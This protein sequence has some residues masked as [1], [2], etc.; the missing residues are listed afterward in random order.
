METVFCPQ[1]HQEYELD[2]SVIGCRV[3][4]AI[5]ETEFIA[6]PSDCPADKGKKEDA[7]SKD[8][9]ASVSCP[10][11]K[12]ANKPETIFCVFCEHKIVN[13]NCPS[14]HATLVQ[15]AAFCPSCG[16]KVIDSDNNR[17]VGSED[18]SAHKL[19][20][21]FFL[22]KNNICDL[23][24]MLKTKFMNMSKKKRIAIVS[25]SLLVLLFCVF[26]ISSISGGTNSDDSAAN[27]RVTSRGY[28]E[29]QSEA[30]AAALLFLMTAAAA[31]QNQGSSQ[32]AM[33]AVCTDCGG[34]GYKIG[35]F[36][37]REHCRTC[38]GT[39]YVSKYKDPFS[40][41]NSPFQ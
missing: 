25:A 31:Q 33:P 17:F 5:C 22:L 32:N 8:N 3:Q 23:A 18:S 2:E 38:K 16:K 11:C 34:L 40:F 19:G 27:Q 37:T 15:G 1:C 26:L 9:S 7:S 10:H 21:R 29:K 39:G 35:I 24:S 30:D 4:C 6:Q 28:A 41:S 20:K 14:C 12:K 13:S 36:G